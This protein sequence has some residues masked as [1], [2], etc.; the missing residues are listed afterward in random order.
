MTFELIN[1][2]FDNFFDSFFNQGSYA[3]RN[4]KDNFAPN[5][6]YTE[7]EK[8]YY[9]NAEIPGVKKDDLKVEVKGDE[10]KI[11]GTRG[12]KE[13]QKDGDVTRIEF[14]EFTKVFRLGNLV[15][16]EH[17][18]AKHEDGMLFLTIPKTREA[19]ARFID[20]K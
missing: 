12:S 4:N 2:N 15:D 16:L 5:F 7:D 8:N 1:R 18:E 11:S 6:T 9:L 20:V 13:P 10:L 3:L 14:G 17:I 19:Q